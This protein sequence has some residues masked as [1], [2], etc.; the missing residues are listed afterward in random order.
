MLPNTSSTRKTA[1]SL[2]LE[3]INSKYIFI[4]VIIT[5]SL[6]VYLNTMSNGFVYDDE[7]QILQNPWIKD[8]RYIPNIFS[9][10]MWAFESEHI[11]NYYRPIIHILYMA[12]YYIFGLNPWGFRLSFMLLHAGASVLVFLIASKLVNYLKLRTDLESASSLK[13]SALIAA[14]LFAT[15]PIHTEALGW[16]GGEPLFAFFYLSSFYLYMKADGTRGRW[17]ILSLFFFFLATLCKETALT[18][19]IFLIVYD[20][21]LSSPLPLWERVKAR[22]VSDF[23]KY[24]PF[25]IVAGIY[26]ILRI[27]FIGGITPLKRHTELSNYEYLINIFPL[28]I[29]YLEKLILPINLSVYHV[30]HPIHSIIEWKGMLSVILTLLFIGIVYLSRKNRIAV[31]SLL[32]MVIPLLPAMY[33]PALGENT[34]TERYLYLPSVGFV[35]LMAM[36]MERIFV[37]MLCVRMKLIQEK[38]A[39]IA[40]ISMLII[41]TSLYSIG[42]IKRNLIYRD[43]YTLWSDTVEKAP[44]GY[45]PHYNLGMI[46]YEKGLLDKAIEHYQAAIRIIPDFVEAYNNTG[47]AYLDKG[48]VEKAI[49]YFQTAIRLAPD[50]T[51]AYNNLG[52][53]YTMKGLKDEARKAFETALKLKPDFRQARRG[54]ERLDSTPR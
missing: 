30:F 3:L 41:I 2:S 50:Y 20:Y 37:L 44:D 27:Y 49:E 32:W 52:V 8:V 21:S 18:L 39:G 40:T 25:L 43:N 5:V 35:I 19:P 42:T 48:L 14:I 4:A 23:K 54:L 15:H 12:D 33:I 13:W 46:Y 6:V 31:F 11:S 7:E 17:F 24:F 29:Q 38:T 51:E 16:G 36:L 28:F 45:M 26:F 53:A 22:G 47:I 10:A 1:K 34:F 9:S